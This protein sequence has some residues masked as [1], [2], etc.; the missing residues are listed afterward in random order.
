VVRNSPTRLPWWM[1][2]W[3]KVMWCCTRSIR[4][5]AMRRTEVSCW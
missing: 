3:G 5:G 2:R 4:C 1:F